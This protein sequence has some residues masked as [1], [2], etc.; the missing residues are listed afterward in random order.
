MWGRSLAARAKGWRNWCE[1]MG[2]TILKHPAS[3]AEAAHDL[4]NHLQI[5]A[6]AVHLIERGVENDPPLLPLAPHALDSI[7]R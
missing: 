7:D 3:A 4:G 5:I 1:T 2:L 6:S